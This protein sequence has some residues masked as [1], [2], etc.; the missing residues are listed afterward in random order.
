VAEAKDQLDYN[1]ILHHNWMSRS[2]YRKP[3]FRVTLETAARVKRAA[4]TRL[5]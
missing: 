3:V 1:H 4:E 5:D 2:G